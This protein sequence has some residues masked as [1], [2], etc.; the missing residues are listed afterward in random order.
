MMS[1]REIDA[2]IF[3]A[4]ASGGLADVATYRPTVGAPVSVSVMIDQA[5]QQVEG[6]LD[7]RSVTDTAQI[8]IERAALPQVPERGDLIELA[9]GRVYTVQRREQSDESTWVLMCKA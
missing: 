6:L 4:M 9:D 2:R 7:V 3:R 1:L 8:R 5:I